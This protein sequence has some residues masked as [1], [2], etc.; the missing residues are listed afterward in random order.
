MTNLLGSPRH[1]REHR[2]R[3]T[4]LALN[5]ARTAVVSILASFIRQSVMFAYCAYAVGEKKNL[6]AQ[7]PQ[8]STG[9]SICRAAGVEMSDTT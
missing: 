9:S 6:L 8:S 4:H 3:D 2:L 5:D 7:F 1:Q